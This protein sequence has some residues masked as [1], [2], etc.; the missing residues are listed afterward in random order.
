MPWVLKNRRDQTTL[1]STVV[2]CVMHRGK[3]ASQKIKLKKCLIHVA[4]FTNNIRARLISWLGKYIFPLPIFR[5][6]SF[7]TIPE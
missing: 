7:G 6:R 1:G 3:E 4:S 2:N 5:A